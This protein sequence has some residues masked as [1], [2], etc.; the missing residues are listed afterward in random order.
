MYKA[1]AFKELE[2]AGITGSW[3]DWFLEGIESF[4]G[5]LHD[6]FRDSGGSYDVVVQLKHADI[7]G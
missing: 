5:V 2:E 4:H 1:G 3:L 6:P 7:P